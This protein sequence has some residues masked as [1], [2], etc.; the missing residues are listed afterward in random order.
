MSPF[1]LLVELKSV[2]SQ[3]GRLIGWCC[4]FLSALPYEQLQDRDNGQVISESP[5]SFSL[6]R[7]Y[8]GFSRF[9]NTKLVNFVVI[10]VV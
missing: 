7:L 8:T 2:C 6:L 4:G 5:M 9:Q 3:Q 10:V 1:L